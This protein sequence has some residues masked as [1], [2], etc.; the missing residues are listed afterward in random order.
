MNF[1]N[2]PGPASGGF[3]EQLLPTPAD[4]PATGNALLPPSSPTQQLVA[5]YKLFNATTPYNSGTQTSAPADTAA[6]M[7]NDMLEQAQDG[8][9]W[10]PFRSGVRSQAGRSPDRGSRLYRKCRSSAR[11]ET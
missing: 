9:T 6:T 8:D 10:P 3:S 7:Q 1:A 2:R 4:M 5:M 11:E